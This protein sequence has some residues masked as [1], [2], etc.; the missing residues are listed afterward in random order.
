MNF[1]VQDNLGKGEFL[2]IDVTTL[3]LTARLIRN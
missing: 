2:E 3:E 1:N